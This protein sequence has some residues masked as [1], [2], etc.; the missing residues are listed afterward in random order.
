MEL[1]ILS[2]PDTHTSKPE[3]ERSGMGFTVMETFMDKVDIESYIGEGTTIRM[4]KKITT[5]K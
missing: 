1:Q 3:L 2:L 5:V 4:T